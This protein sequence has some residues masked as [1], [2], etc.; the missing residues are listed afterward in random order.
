MSHQENMI[1]RT[2]GVILVLSCVMSA[3]CS[4]LPET[5]PTTSTITYNKDAVPSMIAQADLFYAR[6]DDLTQLEQ[7]IVLL[8][9]ATTA[10]PNNYDAF[11]RLAKFDYYLASHTDGDYQKRAFREGVDAGKSAIALQPDKP[12]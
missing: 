11:W 6:R 3:A 9:Q 5:D 7:G 10:D 2:T 1:I 12:D 4:W 8:R